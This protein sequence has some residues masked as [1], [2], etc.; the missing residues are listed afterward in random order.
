MGSNELFSTQKQKLK[1]QLTQKKLFVSYV[2]Q[3]CKFAL[4]ALISFWFSVLL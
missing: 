2:T 3:I 4:E 1:K